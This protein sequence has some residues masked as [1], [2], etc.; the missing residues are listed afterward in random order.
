MKGIGIVAAVIGVVVGSS[1][2]FAQ[3]QSDEMSKVQAIIERSHNLQNQRRAQN[4]F[5]RSIAEGSRNDAKQQM[6]TGGTKPLTTSNQP[7]SISKPAAVP[8]PKPAQMVAAGHSDQVKQLE[9]QITE[10][11]QANTLFQQ[12]TDQRIDALNQEHATLQGKLTKVAQVLAMLNQEITQLGQQVQSAQQQLSGSATAQKTAFAAT[13]HNWIEKIERTAPIQYILYA[14]LALLAI[15]ILMLI[16]RRAKPRMER[17]AAESTAGA[18]ND[19]VADTKGEYDFMGSE[20]AIP[21]KLDLARA[22]MAMEDYHS[23]KKV[24]QQVMQIGDE[25][26]RQEAKAMLDKIPSK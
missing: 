14:I 18:A 1:A 24:L 22:Y 15:I 7:A 25:A 6:V 12:Q 19:G 9:T 3:S 4:S 10:L 5:I 11:N 8:T 21:A 26:Q 23:A 2:C 17:V 20:E 16:P 13:S